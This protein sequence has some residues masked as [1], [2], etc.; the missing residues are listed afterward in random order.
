MKTFLENK[1]GLYAVENWQPNCWVHVEC[2]TAEDREYLINELDL[3]ESFLNDIEDIDERPRVEDEDGWRLIIIRTPFL[4]LDKTLPYS[5]VPIGI[6]IKDNILVT[7]C[8]YKTEML[9]DFILYSKRKKV[10]ILNG[11]D[12]VFKLLLSSAIWFLKYLKQISLMIKNAENELERS[13]KNQ[14]LQALLR[15]EKCLVFFITSLKGDSILMHKLNNIKSQIEFYDPEQIEDVEIE[16]RQALETANIHSDILSGMMDAYASI[17]SNNLNVI[18][19]QLTSISIILMIPTLISSMYGMNVPNAFQHN[20]F[21]FFIILFGSFGFSILV[22][23]LFLK[24][25]WF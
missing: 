10:T 17:I 3:P 6:I 4:A 7:V 9:S 24:K 19:K 21:G 2:P 20:H 13:I 11:Y 25:K 1:D 12:L 15:L 22:F 5:T 8:H 14:D 16:L 18:M 23:M